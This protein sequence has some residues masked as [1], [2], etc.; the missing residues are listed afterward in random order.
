MCRLQC[1]NSAIEKG[2][3]KV[4]EIWEVRNQGRSSVLRRWGLVFGFF[5]NI[6]SL[7]CSRGRG[8]LYEKGKVQ[9]RIE[10]ANEADWCLGGKPVTNHLRFV[11]KPIGRV[12]LIVKRV[13]CSGDR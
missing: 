8:Y 12:T 10:R 13:V 4:R 1:I 7:Y 3:G 9:E 5:W 11:Y 6:L 2:K